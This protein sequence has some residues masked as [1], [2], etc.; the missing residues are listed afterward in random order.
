M[1]AFEDTQADRGLPSV[2]NQ[3]KRVQ[4]HRQQNTRNEEPVTM[5]F[6]NRRLRTGHSRL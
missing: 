1:P 3:G 2:R 5:Y 4:Q 6:D